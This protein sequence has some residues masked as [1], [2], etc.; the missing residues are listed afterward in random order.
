MSV[1]KAFFGIDL[2][3][4][5]SSIAY[6]VD[7]P[8]QHKS[9]FITVEV[10]PANDAEGEKA[11]RLPTLVSRNFTDKRKKRLLIGWEVLR[12]FAQHR[13]DNRP[14]RHGVDFFRSVKS[15]MGSNRVYP[16][17]FSEDCNTPVKVSEK[18]VS[19]LIKLACGRLS[20]QDPRNAQVVITVPASFNAL[21]REDTLQAA[22]AAGLQRGSVKLLD[23]PVAALLDL[24]NH[25]NAG[26]VLDST[27]YKNLLVFDYGGGTCDLTLVRARFD[28]KTQTG[29]HVETLAI[30][31]YR[32]LGGDDIDRR[33]MSEVVWPQICDQS[34]ESKLDRGTRRGVED[35]LTH[36]VARGLKER[37]CRKGVKSAVG[38]VQMNRCREP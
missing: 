12:A 23:E 36:T 20:S 26:L 7:D 22:Y 37:L 10:V 21:A 15:D 13:R 38:C 27:E 16:R 34:D 25:S 17:A 29:L 18:V 31:Q 3:T 2:G 33:V 4:S 8:R 1:N 35:T 14:N 5:N 30:S 6:V 28:D 32:Q 19:H 24:L 11:N 9:Q